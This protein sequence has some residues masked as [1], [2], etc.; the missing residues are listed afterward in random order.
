MRTSPY[1][2]SHK[3]NPIILIGH[4]LGGLVIK[5]AYIASREQKADPEFAERIQAVFFL[6]TPHRGSAYASTLSNI[7]KISGFLSSPEYLSEL[8]TGSASIQLINQDFCRY[9]GDLLIFSFFETLSMSLG[10]LASALIVE[11]SSAILGP[12]VKTERVQYLD[13]NHR[14]VCKFDGL[15]DPNYLRVRDSL[16]TALEMLLRKPRTD[17]NA[18]AKARLATLR[19]YLGVP[20]QQ[21]DHRSQMEGSC[22]WIEHRDDF[23]QWLAGEDAN[24]SFYVMTAQPGAGKTILASHV[25]SQLKALNMACAFHFLQF[26]NDHSQSLAGLLRSIAYQMASTTTAFRDV[27]LKLHEDGLTFAMDDARTIW[28]NIFRE[29]LFRVSASMTRFSEYDYRLTN[30][31]GNRLHL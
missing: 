3:R 12:E 7:L 29:C 23:Q 31:M 17:E 24:P 13:A 1:L 15:D 18:E 27:L 22:R 14:D 4:S 16:A 19:S 20:G 5:K 10:G 2:R 11:K 26:G 28:V 6:A 9:A 8:T 21:E 25:I 30:V